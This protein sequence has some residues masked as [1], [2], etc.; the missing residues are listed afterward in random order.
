MACERYRNFSEEAKNK[1]HYCC[2]HYK[3]L[4]EDKKQ[5]LVEYRKN[6]FRMQ[7]II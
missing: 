5:R 7:K 3:N 2:E 4:P 6:Y 1:H